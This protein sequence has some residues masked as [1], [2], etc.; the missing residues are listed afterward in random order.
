MSGGGAAYQQLKRVDDN[1]QENLVRLGD[2][3]VRLRANRQAERQAEA[4][5][6]SKELADWEKKYG[7]NRDDFKG[8]HT[9]FQSYDDVNYD[10]INYMT[11]E[12]LKIQREAENASP[13]ERRKMTSKLNK[14]MAN[15]D[16]MKEMSEFYATNYEGY[17]EAAEAG[18]VSGSS[19]NY[20]SD[21]QEMLINSNGAIRMDDDYNLQYHVVRNGED[22]SQIVSKYNYNDIMDG[23]V[24]W[25]EKIDLL[26]DEG[27]VNQLVD[28]L[29][30]NTNTTEDGFTKTTS[31]IWDE[32]IQGKATDQL[33]EMS[34]NSDSTMA[35]LLDQTMEE[36]STKSSGFTQEEYDYV[37]GRLKEQVKNSYDTK[38][39][40][41]FNSSKANYSLGV[42][43]LQLAKDK[44]KRDANK[45]GD[46]TR[47]K[48][49]L[50]QDSIDFVSGKP[51]V[52]EGNLTLDGVDYNAYGSIDLG[53]KVKVLLEDNKGN[54]TEEIIPKTKSGFLEF[55]LRSESYEGLN[56]ETV[57]ATDPQVYQD[58]PNE[59]TR[60]VVTALK[61]KFKKEDGSFNGDDTE[62]LADLKEK[63]PN[64]DIAEVREL[65]NNT[66]KIKGEVIDLDDTE[67]FD[68]L[69]TLLEEDT[70][71]KESDLEDLFN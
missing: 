3:A 23:T 20:E 69:I 6:N 39:K 65:E 64:S 5:R 38:F 60:S 52:I 30:K 58:V 71:I 21:I 44:A 10:A 49:F 32:E 50:H 51:S 57:L 55:K 41:E 17:K 27:Y 59:S 11:D 15:V 61:R 47:L 8:K 54:K 1:I 22:G 43:R 13:I 31:Q 46:K 63:Y 37:K 26:G 33:I 62:L 36:G 2:Q 70:E 12:Y 42:S 48:G 40:E 45:D 19:K 66:V 56:R 34:L 18:K 4:D 35:D 67:S 9:G 29:G 53:D 16:R 28:T 68:K 14:I 25:N 7:F 24:S